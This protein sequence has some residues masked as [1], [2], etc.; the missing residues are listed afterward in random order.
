VTPRD[1]GAGGSRVCG[2]R[3]PAST[4]HRA[5]RVP[6][7]RLPAV[8]PRGREQ[9]GRCRRTPP[10][11]RGSL[12]ARPHAHCSDSAA[13]CPGRETDGSRHW[14]EI[15]DPGHA[16]NRHIDTGCRPPVRL[17]RHGVPPRFD[18]MT[19][20]EP[21]VPERRFDEKPAKLDRNDICGRSTTR[22]RC[23]VRPGR[24][25]AGPRWAFSATETRS[26]GSPPP[27]GSRTFRSNR[28][29]AGI[30]LGVRFQARA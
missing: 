21:I 10:A 12:V 13:P 4:R 16:R 18:R 19:L 9:P 15:V 29:E 25:A 8:L 22:V 28:P 1:L 11:R 27:T 17:V 14:R 26:G 23:R 20:N 2:P 7:R 6:V 3:R 24:A 30:P 5:G